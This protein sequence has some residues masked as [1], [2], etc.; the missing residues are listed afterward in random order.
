[1]AGP[2]WV[3]NLSQLGQG[4]LNG[5][6]ASEDNQMR[7]KAQDHVDIFSTVCTNPPPQLSPGL[8]LIQLQL[9]TPPLPTD[10]E[11]V[12]SNTEG[13]P[14]QPPSLAG[15]QMDSRTCMGN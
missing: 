3:D 7:V 4:S 14:G 6:E 10:T 1:M 9:Y 5:D 15:R 13:S 8:N 11:S 2:S 12:S